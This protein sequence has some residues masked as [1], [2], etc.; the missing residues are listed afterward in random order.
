MFLKDIIISA[1]LQSKI[2]ILQSLFHINTEFPNISKCSYWMTSSWPGGG[3]G[4]WT[5]HL[6]QNKFILI[7]PKLW[8]SGWKGRYFHDIVENMA[9]TP[10]TG[11]AN[12]AST[13]CLQHLWVLIF[14][15]WL[16][17]LYNSCHSTVYE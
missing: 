4:L 11:L 10:P 5:H 2:F 12:L 13:H 3:W 14:F 16:P 15:L 7:S 8:Y 6:F 17:Y 9:P 1:N